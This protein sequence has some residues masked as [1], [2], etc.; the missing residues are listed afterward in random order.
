VGNDHRLRSTP[1]SAATWTLV[2]L[3]V[4]EC[5]RAANR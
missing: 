3:T 2:I 4:R 5:Q 1:P